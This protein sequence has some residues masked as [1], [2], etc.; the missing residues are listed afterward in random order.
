MTRIAGI[1][2]VAW[3]PLPV[4]LAS[5]QTYI[6]STLA[7]MTAGVLGWWGACYPADMLDSTGVAT[8]GAALQL[9]NKVPGGAALQFHD[10]GGI[11][12][13]GVSTGYHLIPR[14]VGPEA[15]IR[16]SFNAINGENY[17]APANFSDLFLPA[18][19]MGST[20]ARTLYLVMSRVNREQN[21]QFGASPTLP[22][23][24][25]GTTVILSLGNAGNGL[26]RL[27]LYPGTASST[28]L[29][30][31]PVRFTQSITL[32]MTA[33]GT[34][35]LWIGD[36]RAVAGVV[37]ALP[38]TQTDVLHFAQSMDFHEGWLADHAI[39]AAE[40][41]TL[42]TSATSCS[43]Q[44]K[45]GERILPLFPFIGQSN[46]AKMAQAGGFMQLGEA[47]RW[48]LGALG[49]DITQGDDRS[50]SRGGL[51]IGGSPLV[52]PPGGTGYAYIDRNGGTADPATWPYTAAGTTFI[53]WF[54]GL[55]A[56]DKLRLA[57]GG[58]LWPYA[59][60][61]AANGH[62]DQAN[63]EFCRNRV[64][65]DA[66]A[67]CGVF[68]AVYSFNT[69]AFGG[70]NPVYPS[71]GS[72]PG[73]QSL[74]EVFDRTIANVAK[75]E[76]RILHNLADADNAGPS[77]YAHMSDATY[78][79][80]G[81][82]AGLVLANYIAQDASASPVT[83]LPR[84][85]PQIASALVES[86]TSILV[87]ILPDQG[88]DIQVGVPSNYGWTVFEGWATADAVGT[89]RAVAAC[90]RVNTR[91]FR[92]TLSDAIVGAAS[93]VRVWS[94]YGQAKVYTGG[95]AHDNFSTTPTGLALTAA[96]GSAYTQ[97]Y[98]I[99]IS[100]YGTICT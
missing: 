73:S 79:K 4:S 17:P 8:V 14:L 63:Y 48:A 69:W 97:D 28:D 68:F 59:E 32:V 100:T 51:D 95:L 49:I 71:G 99:A 38:A 35:D 67:A 7:T 47:C 6:G 10:A 55:S 1:S 61:D 86:P 34:T 45:R 27:T 37:T 25:L 84:T 50:P 72:D 43:K 41:V 23:I 57:A 16:N 53:A 75:K 52:Q 83:G 29:G 54:A 56:I 20:V 60:S 33:S 87:T 81:V 80:F 94:A 13:Q 58:L 12:N 78:R 66:R 39:T 89:N 36:T 96:L 40:T 21:G 22:L 62:G 5:V 42:L 74:R 77:D 90:A 92:L 76:V 24:T 85:G 18:S 64:I 88:T 11:T 30:L 2:G 31:V 98:P 70:N 82:R 65:A 93:T 3:A 46:G 26:D 19:T 9:R 15:G 44:W 91:Q